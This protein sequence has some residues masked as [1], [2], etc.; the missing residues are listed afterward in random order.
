MALTEF[1]RTIC[2]LVARQRL[3]SGESYV[4]GAAALNALTG[5]TRISRDIDLF[6]DTSVA[7]AASFEADSDLLMSHGYQIQT[8]KERDGFVESEAGKAGQ[9]VVLQG[10]SDSAFRFF[11][12]DE[13]E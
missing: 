11:P 10:T 13:H 1:Q 9:S 8:L 12:L 3:E 6:H 7:V 4:A 5:A 2:R